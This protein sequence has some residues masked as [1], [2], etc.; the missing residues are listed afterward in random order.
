MNAQEN[1][2]GGVGEICLSRTFF[3]NFVPT[4]SSLSELKLVLY[5]IYLIHEKGDA[6]SGITA[7]E[8]W[9]NQI[10][11]DMLCSESRSAEDV[12]QAALEN[13]VSSGI[14]LHLPL[15]VAGKQEDAYFLN[16]ATSKEAIADVQSGGNN[17]A[18]ILLGNISGMKTEEE[19]NIFSL[20]EE[21]IG[22]LTPMIVEQLK[23]AQQIYPGSWIK[24][25]F[26]EASSLNK[27]N[28]RYIERI[29]ERWSREG[30][31]YG[32]AGRYTKESDPDKYIKGKYGHIVRR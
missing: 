32:A 18:D 17:P 9:D 29:L 20:Y 13:A 27:R 12:I 11:K 19:A 26:R 3:S 31:A 8:L 24:D 28:W 30:R 21:N 6:F 4:I 1:A 2:P 5:I 25:A 15:K 7:G 23:E 22:I 10:I 14:L 16:T